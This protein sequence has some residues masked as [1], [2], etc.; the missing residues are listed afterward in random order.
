[1][2]MQAEAPSESWLALPAVIHL[3]GPMTDKLSRIALRS[4]SSFT[5][6]L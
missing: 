6:E 4:G 3:S 1:M 2:T 5:W